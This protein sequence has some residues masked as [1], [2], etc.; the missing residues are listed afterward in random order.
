MSEE[1]LP[2]TVRSA[3]ALGVDDVAVSSACSDPDGALLEHI[4]SLHP[5][6]LDP[7]HRGIETDGPPPGRWALMP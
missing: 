6:V 4:S 2:I 7:F 1:T 3:L 5:G